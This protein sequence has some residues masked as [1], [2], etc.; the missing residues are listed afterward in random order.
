MAKIAELTS[1]YISEHPS[2]KECLAK[3]VVNYSKLARRISSELKI[4]STGAVVAAC[5]RCASSLRKTSQDSG[6]DILKKSKKRI[7]I[8]G[9][10]AHI[11]LSV[12]EKDLPKILAAMK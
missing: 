12:S 4:S 5:Q 2:L 9:K 8:D 7:E 10:Q 1:R 3:N 11:T 6:M